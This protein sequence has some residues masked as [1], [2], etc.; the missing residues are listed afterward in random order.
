P[1]RGFALRQTDRYLLVSQALPADIVRHALD[2]QTAY[3]EYQ[4]RALGRAGLRSMYIGILTLTLVLA[5]FGAFLLAAILG[6]QL[7]RPLLLL[8]AGV[9]EVAR[10]DLRPK[11]IFTSQDELG[12]LTR[13]F[14][15][16]TQQLADARQLAEHSVQELDSARAHLQT[17]LDNLNAGVL[18][19]DAAGCLVLVNPGATRIL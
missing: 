13:A 4:Q 10:G 7:A 1:D 18:V 17:V 16:M 12:G 14:A 11:A 5:V 8:A 9:E 2:V 3:R 15:A 6:Q 19:F